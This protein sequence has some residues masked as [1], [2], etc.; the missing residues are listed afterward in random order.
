MK[1]EAERFM[2]TVAVNAIPHFVSIN[3]SISDMFG[4]WLVQTYGNIA[5]HDYKY[6]TNHQVMWP[7]DL[8]KEP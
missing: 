4:S 8:Y 6:W 2:I 7:T 1:N 3:I 5:A